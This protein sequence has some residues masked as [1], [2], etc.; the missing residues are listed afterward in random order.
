MTG[1]ILFGGLD[2]AKYTGPLVA[3][4]VQK[5]SNGTYK[6][7][8]VALSSFSL[9]DASGKNAYQKNNLALPVILDSGTTATYLPDNIATD[10][11][12]G[13][14]AIDD[15]QGGLV[16]PCNL[17]GS[18]AKLLFAFGGNGG[19]SIQVSLSEFIIPVYAQDGSQPLFKDGSGAICSFGL[20][21]SGAGDQPILLGDTFL[22]SA[23]VVYDLANNQIGLAQTKFNTTDT[24]VVEIS[25]TSIPGVT[26]TATGAAVTQSYTGHPLQTDANTKL[27]GAV[28]TG[29]PNKPTFSLGVPT[30]GA[31]VTLGPPRVE[32]TT[33]VTG[34]AIV[35]S[36]ILGSSLVMMR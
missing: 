11:I 9:T 23:Y 29:V 32:V 4:P 30:K 34:L 12:K 15:G 28:F 27:N 3:L 6:D 1:S 22:R 19:P 8:T 25:E 24:H 7:F 18:P 13:V 2:T 5:G 31:A 14:G 21:S 17:A 33:L 20:M 10:I 36:M 26:S 35:M 16:V